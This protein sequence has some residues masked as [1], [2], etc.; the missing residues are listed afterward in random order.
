MTA[1]A[2]CGKIA[3]HPRARF[4][5]SCGAMLGGQPNPEDPWIG[6]VV[7][8]RY[9]VVGVL[10]EGGMGRIYLAEQQMGR[11]ARKVA[12]KTLQP[13]RAADATIAKRFNRE[14][15]TVIRLAHPNT[16]TFY[17][18]G[19]TPDGTLYIVME[20]IKGESVAQALRAG[21]MPHE[22][23]EHILEQICSSLH[24][25]HEMGIVH[26]DL[27]PENIILTQRVSQAD[28]V[29]VLDFGIAKRTELDPESLR[30]TRSGVVLG[31]PPY[32]S[33]EQFAGQPLDRRS[34]IY[35]LGVTTYEM[36]TGRL[37]F[38][39]KTAW[40]WATQHLSTPPFPFERTDPKG[41]VPPACRRA[42]L[43]ALAKDAGDRPAT[44]VAFL[45]ELRGAAAI[46][47][48]LASTAPGT[49]L[50][51]DDVA[52]PPPAP[53]SGSFATVQTPSPFSPTTT[54][55]GPLPRTQQVQTRG[56]EAEEPRLRWWHVTALVCIV[57]MLL[58]LGV[59]ALLMYL[60]VL[61]LPV[62]VEG[63]L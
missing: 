31:T 26:R 20:Y 4:C 44:V 48:A 38:E 21:P 17:D 24:E 13:D 46:T 29:K 61:P 2:T 47:P 59:G 40:E 32:M 3:D 7:G 10:G 36:L 28:F 58:G 55:G 63:G 11:I 41:A 60:G 37:P 50:G 9:R 8:G 42:V 33:P 19:Q 12:I 23:V 53:T 5:P 6:Q 16:I 39:A 56:G 49:G 25:A 15:E 62:W 57:M 34:D 43:R 22:R 18:F 35:S 51:A 54:G 30:L 14:A 52:T 45:E 27:K 1:C